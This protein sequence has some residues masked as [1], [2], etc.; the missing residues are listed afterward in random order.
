MPGRV[1]AVVLTLAL[2]FAPVEASPLEGDLDDS[3]DE[4]AAQQQAAEDELNVL[5]ASD[6]QLESEL[7]RLGQQIEDHRRLLAVTSW[8]IMEAEAEMARLNDEILAA[9][10]AVEEATEA[11]KERAIDAYMQPQMAEAA[12]LLAAEDMNQF[13]ERLVMIEQLHE[14]DREILLAKEEAERRLGEK[15]AEVAVAEAHLKELHERTNDALAEMEADQHQQLLVKETLDQRIAELEDEIGALEAEEATIASLIAARESEVGG[16]PAARAPEDEPPSAPAPVP[17][18]TT[19][20]I[21]NPPSDG[22][23]WPTSGVVT[24]EFG[25]RWGRMHNGID[26]AAPLGTSIW[27]AASGQVFFVGYQGGYGNTVMIDHGNGLVTLYAHQS[28]MAVYSGQYV[29]Q[30][31]VIGYVGSTGNSTGPHLHFETRVNGAPQ[32]PRNHLP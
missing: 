28:S 20:T 9:E 2:L 4:N 3:L 27:A 19:T 10:Q 22:L 24:S 14:R 1:F 15:R 6:L 13:G 17:T 32:N 8:E 23:I 5:E 30:G 25:M 31:Q 12:A 11:V 29:D 26:I 18:T 7:S 16:P 21:A